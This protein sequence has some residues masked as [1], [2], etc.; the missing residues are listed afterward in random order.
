MVS[1]SSTQYTD[2]LCPECNLP[3][4]LEDWVRLED[5]FTDPVFALDLSKIGVITNPIGIS[6]LGK[7]SSSVEEPLP[8]P[9]KAPATSAEFYV[10]LLTG[11][12]FAFPLKHHRSVQAL[13]NALEKVTNAEPAKQKLIFQGIEL[14]VSRISILP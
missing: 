12:R 2:K 5:A 6:Q 13:K 11:E 9:G 7:A 14:D 4:S 3:L 8:V 10:I 1:S